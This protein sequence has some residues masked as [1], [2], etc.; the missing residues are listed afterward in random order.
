MNTTSPFVMTMGCMGTIASIDMIESALYRNAIATRDSGVTSGALSGKEVF[1]MMTMSSLTTPMG[2]VAYD[3][4]RVNSNAQGLLLQVTFILLNT[5]Y[6]LFSFTPITLTLPFHHQ[7]EP[8]RNSDCTNCCTPWICRCHIDL[9]H[10]FLGW[11]N[12]SMVPHEECVSCSCDWYCCGKLHDIPSILYCSSRPNHLVLI[13]PV[14][15]RRYA[16][17]SLLS[18]LSRSPL[19]VTKLILKCSDIL[20]SWLCWQ[21]VFAACGRWCL[22]GK[23]IWTKPNA[24]R[25]CGPSVCLLVSPFIWSISKPTVCIHFLP[26]P[27]KIPTT[28]DVVRQS[29]KVR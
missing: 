5:T 23:T 22:S 13:H 28:N 29:V 18:S 9:P 3:V 4:N 6:P 8:P 24:L 11:T 21:H 25:I 12:L 7:S 1:D 20:T 27:C 17:P 2:R 10:S 26:L 14:H 19:I 16:R 15:P